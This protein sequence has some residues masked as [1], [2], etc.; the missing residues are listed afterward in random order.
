[1]HFISFICASYSLTH[2]LIGGSAE[3]TVLDLLAG[4]FRVSHL[5]MRYCALIIHV[6]MGVACVARVIDM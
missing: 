1:M 2:S 4:V 3:H 6:F 5:C